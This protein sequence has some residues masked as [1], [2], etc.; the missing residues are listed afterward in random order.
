MET[1][2]P[3]LDEP[4]SMVL[5]EHDD[6]VGALLSVTDA[7]V[8]SLI[9]SAGTTSSAPSLSNCAY[10]TLVMIGGACLVSARRAHACADEEFPPDKYIPGALTLGWSLRCVGAQGKSCRFRFRDDLHQ[11]QKHDFV[12]LTDLENRTHPALT[13]PA[14]ESWTSP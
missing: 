8:C 13:R 1:A 6:D 11:K 5:Q 3:K 10:V 7:R 14:N 9:E 2:S 12:S 4:S